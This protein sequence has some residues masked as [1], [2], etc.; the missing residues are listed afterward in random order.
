[1]TEAEFDVYADEYYQQLKSSIGKSG[2]NPEFF[3]EY[4]VKDT[5]NVC[6]KEK[7]SPNVIFDFGSGIGNSI[8][9]FRKYFPNS[10]LI[11]ADISTKS[12]DVSKLRFPGNEVYLKISESGIDFADNSVDVIFCTCVFHHIEESQHVFWLKELNRILKKDGLII[13]FEHNP[14]N[15]LTVSTVKHCPFD[16]NAK[17]IK[18]K[19]IKHTFSLAQ[20]NNSQAVYRFFFPNFLSFFRPIEKWMNRLPLGAQYYVYSKK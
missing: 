20:I 3:A 10:E 19:K 18:A 6:K 14:Y 11:C 9:W 8:P 4:K 7:I 17:L 1:M 13:I 5:L 12:M 16:V 2:E 15:P